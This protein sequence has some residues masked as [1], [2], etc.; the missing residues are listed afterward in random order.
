MTVSLH[1]VDHSSCALTSLADNESV[2]TIRCST[3]SEWHHRP[4]VIISENKDQSF[5]CRRCNV[6]TKPSS[7]PHLG[8]SSQ[9]EPGNGVPVWAGSYG[10]NVDLPTEE[11]MV[12]DIQLLLKMEEEK[13]SKDIS[14][15]F[16]PADDF[17]IDHLQDHNPYFGPNAFSTEV[18]HASFAEQTNH[19]V[20]PQSFHPPGSHFLASF[21]PFQEQSR[22]TYDESRD[23]GNFLKFKR[24]QGLNERGPMFNSSKNQP[25]L[26]YEE[27]TALQGSMFT[28]FVR[29]ARDRLSQ[30]NKSQ[31]PVGYVSPSH[32]HPVGI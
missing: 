32:H 9:P 25:E 1:E 21:S 11:G 7:L 12:D 23:S 27:S 17:K 16:L 24:S 2:P 31:V 30:L 18:S 28:K 29:D 8:Q 6:Q 15:P 14:F 10:L 19:L 22:Q 26:V 5:V 13:K 3:C 20:A 4:C